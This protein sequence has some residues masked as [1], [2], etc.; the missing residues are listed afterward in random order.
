MPSVADVG[1]QETEHQVETRAS[2]AK[3]KREIAARFPEDAGVVDAQMEYFDDD[4]YET[5]IERFCDTTNAAMAKRDEPL[6][7]AHL[8]FLSQQLAETDEEGRQAIDVAYTENLM[9]NLD[10]EAKRWAWPRIP[11]NLQQLYVE[12]WG[13]PK[14]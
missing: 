11:A 6:V 2:V 5:W 4:A 3:I 10:A 1:Y 14:L 7:Q 12:M 8:S 9:W 13:E